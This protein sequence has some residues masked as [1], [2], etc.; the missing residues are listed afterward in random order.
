MSDYEAMYKALFNHVTD[1]IRT[2]QTGQL[3]AEEMFLTGEL[4]RESLIDEEL[5]RTFLSDID[6]IDVTE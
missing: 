3:I 4:A 5:V 2:L 6:E 1:A